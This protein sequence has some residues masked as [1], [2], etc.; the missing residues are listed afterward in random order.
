[1]SALGQELLDTIRAA[2]GEVQLIGTDRLQLVAPKALPDELVQRVRGNKLQLLEALGGSPPRLVA[3]FHDT[4]PDPDEEERAAIIEH[5]GGAPRAWAD[6]F[7]RLHPDRPPPDV[8]Y[9]QWRQFVDDCGLFIDRWAVKS[10]ALGW[11][12]EHLFGWETCRPFPLAAM[13]IGLGWRIDGGTVVVLTENAA[14]VVQANGQR[15]TLERRA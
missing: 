6:A 4:P 14:V 11:I 2:G 3:E 1:M 13:H 8:S 7:A 10:G 12:P 15:F 9:R 5:D